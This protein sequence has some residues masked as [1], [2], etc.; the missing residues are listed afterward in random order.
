M[1]PFIGQLAVFGFDFTPRGWAPCDG[2]LLQISQNTALYALLG[3]AFGGDGRTTFAVPDLRG[4]APIHLGSGPG[5]TPRRR[6]DMGG[7]ETVALSSSQM[8]AH[9]HTLRASSRVADS[10]AP[11]GARL[12]SVDWGMYTSA[13]ADRFLAA[14]SV[15]LAGSGQPFSIMPPFLVLNWC[16][17]TEGVFPGRD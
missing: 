11:D 13:P 17:A 12:A 3:T 9:N 10:F 1:E 2:R 8:P 14:D 15:A 6:G 16:I 4:R 5:L 7:A